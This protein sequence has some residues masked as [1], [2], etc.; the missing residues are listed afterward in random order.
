MVDAIDFVVLWVDDSDEQWKKE[1]IEYKHEATMTDNDSIGQIRYEE[2]GMLQYWFRGV[3]KFTPWV[4]KVH[5]V[6]NGQIPKW[7]NLDHPKLHFV[8]HCDF[9]D[10]KYLP[11]F[12]ANPIENNIFRIEGLADKFVYFN[13][14]MYVIAPV[15]ESFFFKEDLPCDAAILTK[16]KRDEDSSYLCCLANDVDLINKIFNKNLTILRNPM[17]W[18]SLK[19]GLRQF[20]H[21]WWL[22]PSSKFPG[23]KNHH[24]AQPF[25]KS[26]FEKVW[27]VYENELNE[28]NTRR[29]RTKEDL[30]QCLFKYWQLASGTFS[31][32]PL[33]KDRAYFDIKFDT[34]A[35]LECLSQQESKIVCIN[36]ADGAADDYQQ[37]KEVLDKILGEK[38]QYE[39]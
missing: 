29:F 28:A 33:R 32:A 37:V 9:I 19:Y 39:L 8:K 12:N 17:K 36:D 34:P 38:S 20:I 21:P 14:D 6:T 22:I 4:R 31:P 24:S 5:F 10:Q 1:F 35:I 11:L 7:L 23:F 15:S 30:D 13:D 25:L 3:E 27:K 18:L 2:H 16:I 26:T